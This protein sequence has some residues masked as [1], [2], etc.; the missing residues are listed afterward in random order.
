MGLLSWAL[1]KVHPKAGLAFVLSKLCMRLRK[2]GMKPLRLA[3]KIG[4]CQHLPPFCVVS[5][6]IDSGCA[7]TA[8]CIH[9]L[10]APSCWICV[11]DDWD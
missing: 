7:S 11:L 5:L 9:A 3:D 2:A 1:H 10:Q 4:K 8:A 6:E